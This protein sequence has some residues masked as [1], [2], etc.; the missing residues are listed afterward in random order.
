MYPNTNTA[1]A[2]N[3]LK[4]SDK[5]NIPAGIPEPFKQNIFSGGNELNRKTS[6]ED[7]TYQIEVKTAK[8]INVQIFALV[9][10]GTWLKELSYDYCSWDKTTNP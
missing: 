3:L 4:A 1:S 10:K 9:W 5:A 6:V 2:N 8:T 7:V